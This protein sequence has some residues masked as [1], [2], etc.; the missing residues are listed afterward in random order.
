MDTGYDVC[1]PMAHHTDSGFKKNLKYASYE[2][3]LETFEN[4][5]RQMM[6]KKEELAKAGFCYLNIGDMVKCFYCDTGLKDWD[7]LDDPF[8]EHK[9]WCDTNSVTCEYL[10]TVTWDK[11]I[12]TII[13]EKISNATEDEVKSVVET[14]LTCKVCLEKNVSQLLIP[15]GHTLCSDCVFKVTKCPLCNGDFTQINKMFLS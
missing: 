11:K 3:R 12:N 1:G 5:P 9:K 15:C 4:W 14:I 7:I 10:N 6:P 13:D 2:D 8:E